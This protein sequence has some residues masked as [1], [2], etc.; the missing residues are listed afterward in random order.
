MKGDRLIECLEI[1]GPD[2][3]EHRAEELAMRTAE[4]SN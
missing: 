2:P 1:P 3:R 4:A